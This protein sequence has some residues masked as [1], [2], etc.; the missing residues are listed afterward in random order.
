MLPLAAS[1]PLQ[2]LRRRRALH[3]RLIPGTSSHLKLWLQIGLT[4]LP[5]LDRSILSVLLA[6]S[7]SIDVPYEHPLIR[8]FTFVEANELRAVHAELVVAISVTRFS[9]GSGYFPRKSLRGSVTSWRACFPA[10][11]SLWLGS[12]RALEDALACARTG[13]LVDL[14]T[15]AIAGYRGFDDDLYAMEDYRLDDAGACSLASTLPHF[16]ALTKLD[17]LGSAIGEAGARALSAAL[18]SLRVLATLILDGNS[19]AD[20]GVHALAAVLPNLPSLV[21][22]DLRRNS[23]GVEGARSLAAAL[24]SSGSSQAAPPLTYLNVAYNP[25]GKASG[26]QDLAAVLLCL[27]A[28]KTL[29]LFGIDL[30]VLGAAH[31]ATALPS[32]TA[33]EEM[34]LGSNPLGEE[35]VDA[36]AASLPALSMKTLEVC[37]CSLGNAG[38]AALARYLPRFRALESLDCSYNAI[39]NFGNS[40]LAAS[41]C[42]VPTLKSLCWIEDASRLRRGEGFDSESVG[43]LSAALVSTAALET[44]DLNGLNFGDAGMQKLAEVALPSL[45]SLLTLKLRNNAYGASGAA[46][47]AAALP[48]LPL[49]VLDLSGHVAF[50]DEGARVVAVALADNTTLTSLMLDR[51]GIGSAGAQHLCVALR[52]LGSLQTL[53]LTGNAIGAAG[54]HAFAAALSSMKRPLKRLYVNYSLGNADAPPLHCGA[55]PPPPEPQKSVYLNGRTIGGAAQAAVLA[56]ADAVGCEI[57]FF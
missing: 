46:T 15:L 32:L 6:G 28:L 40:L 26:A 45:R 5:G 22:L 19:V 8:F 47:L 53:S 34:L 50:G 18:P 21:Y 27:N 10:A 25:I 23:F 29:D 11:T 37:G 7:D 16:A 31:I 54:F 56:A 9:G 39:G 13:A 4:V 2:P 41:L 44:L 49:K 17:F 24:C 42:G 14:D 38:A 30:D 48:R 57:I 55:R 33:L 52:T 36:L 51:N 20:A 3:P 12:P 43:A 1:P 35:G